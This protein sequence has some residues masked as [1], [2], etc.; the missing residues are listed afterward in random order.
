M[1]AVWR[2]LTDARTSRRVGLLE[3]AHGRVGEV[4][5]LLAVSVPALFAGLGLPFL[6]PDEGLYADITRNMLAGGD[7][8]L[9]RF[10]GLP[11][12]EKPPLFFWLGTVTLGLGAPAE[13]GLRV[14]S[15]VAALGTVL[16]AWRIAQRLYGS[17]AGV[18]AG[19]ALATTA[20]Y[21]LYVRKASTDFV[22]VFC[23]TLSVYGFLRDAERSDRGRLRFLLVYLA[24][25]LGVLTKGLIGVVFPALIVGLSLA[26]VR[27]LSWR[28]LN[29]VR[30]GALF[31]LVAL[32]WHLAVAWQHPEL[33][34][35]Y[36]ID[37]QI[38]RFLN[39]RGF[40]EDDVPVSTLGFLIV[41]FVWLFPWGVFVLARSGRDAKPGARWRSIAVIWALVV[42]GFFALS[43]SKLEYY[44][45]PAFPA[46]AVLVGGAWKA[47]R[48]IGRWFLIG[49]IGTSIVGLAAVWLGAH[50]TA[51]QAFN[52]LAELNVYYRILRDQGAA[53]PYPSPRPFGTLL[54]ALGVTLLAGWCVAAGCWWR[55]WR[56]A[57]F[58]TLVAQ[59]G[60]IGALIV[61]L[62]YVVEPHHS[63][64]A[65]S[66]AIR[67]AATAD[68]VIA[69]EGSLEYSA[70]LPF[71]TGR[72]VVVVD[73]TRGD[74]ELA[75]T[76]AEARGYFLDTGE[77]ARLWSGSRRVFLVT[78]RPRERSVAGGLAG[79][80]VHL[81]G[82]FG[83]RWLYSN[84]ES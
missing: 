70:A 79:E 3:G 83:S 31:A 32:P 53:F 74:L 67:A 71:Y 63:A 55:G 66:G 84:R 80:S 78:Q 1:Q 77:F 44:A 76:F 8:V 54:Q 59:A 15:A 21:G 23:L 35:F 47:G 61:Q 16:L 29:L 26:W 72:R 81:L 17:P 56:C 48:D 39:L 43:R 28:E 45:L 18:L 69:H 36:L 5:L 49:L 75:S 41:S 82:Q 11:Y 4:A 42:I 34:R 20:G 14:W 13:W 40:V 33:F 30:G 6:D 73:G 64:K 46:L 58:G 37:N 68:D 9:P 24:A 38:L 10:N 52:G 7:W 51:D 27:H 19:L 2:T 22:F 60:V 50:L 65:V 57:S 25:A 62:L 12:L